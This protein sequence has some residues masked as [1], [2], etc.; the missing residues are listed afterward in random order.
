M[1]FLTLKCCCRV[2]DFPEA[3]A[4]NLETEVHKQTFQLLS[5]T[6]TVKFFHAKYPR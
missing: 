2:L 6:P 5:R 3:K 1:F 4:S